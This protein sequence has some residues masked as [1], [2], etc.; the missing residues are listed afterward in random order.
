MSARKVERLIALT[1]VLLS[2]HRYLGLDDIRARMPM[3]PEDPESFR[4]AFERDKSDL[5]EMGVPLSMGPLPHEPTIEG[6][7][8][9]PHEY[10]LADPGFTQDELDALLLTSTLVGTGLHGRRALLKL[11]AG[12]QDVESAAEVPASPD[13]V[14]LFGPVTERRTVRFRYRSVDREVNPYRLQFFRGRWY[15]NGFDH[16]RAED[17][18]YRLERID[19]SVTVTD[20]AGAFERPDTAVPGLRVDPWALGESSEPVVVTVWFDPAV[21]AAVRAEIGDGEVRRDDDDGLVVELTVTNRSGFRSWL[22]S[23]LDRAEVLEPA[24]VRAELVEW[25]TGVVDA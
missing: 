21:A 3:Y 2:T 5:R 7:R 17:R 24:E 23:Y 13:L 1:D 12:L 15:L 10:A 19:G 25:L 20:P 11:G 18:W 4:R 8:I 14:A 9:F 6:Y 16:V 22:L